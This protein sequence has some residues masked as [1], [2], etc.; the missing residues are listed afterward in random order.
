MKDFFLEEIDSLIV[1][2]DLRLKL[3]LL[4]VVGRQEIFIIVSF[5]VLVDYRYAAR[6]N[7]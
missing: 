5:L 6:S 3:K 4:R 2:G 1:R 7:D